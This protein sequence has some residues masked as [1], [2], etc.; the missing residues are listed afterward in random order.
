MTCS[1]MPEGFGRYLQTLFIK[2]AVKLW[3]CPLRLLDLLLTLVVVAFIAVL[4]AQA[5]QGL[6]NSDIIK[7]QSAALS[8]GIIPSLSYVTGCLRQS[9]DDISLSE[10][11]G[12]SDGPL[13]DLPQRGNEEWGYCLTHR[14]RNSP[15]LPS[16]EGVKPKRT[17]SPSW[18]KPQPSCV[19]L[20][21][22]KRVTVCKI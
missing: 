9:T 22:E 18:E 19:F 7:M 20:I 12:V 13:H 11:A 8:K 4:P 5:L 14:R 17:L 21:Q 1:L 2:A 10:K 16:V 3:M 6:T 15:R